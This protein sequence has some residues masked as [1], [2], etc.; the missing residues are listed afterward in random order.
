LETTHEYAS[1][2]LEAQG[3]TDEAL[4]GHAQYFRDLR[5][6]RVRVESIGF[7]FDR[8]SA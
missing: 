4:R 3:E 5:A 1:R 6:S 8:R 7:P 2:E